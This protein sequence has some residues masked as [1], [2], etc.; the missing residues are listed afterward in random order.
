MELACLLLGLLLGGIWG[1][2]TAKARFPHSLP[3]APITNPQWDALL[4]FDGNAFPQK[5]EDEWK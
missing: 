1:K 5:E 2:Q 4:A 3:T